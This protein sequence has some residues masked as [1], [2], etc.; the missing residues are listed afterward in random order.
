VFEVAVHGQVDNHSI[1][2]QG[3]S[4]AELVVSFRNKMS[5]AAVMG[6]FTNIL[7]PD[8]SFLVLYVTQLS[9]LCLLFTGI[10][11]LQGR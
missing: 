9:C 7:S 5:L 11:L 2:V 8:H 4:V 1:T 3:A 10:I 6:D